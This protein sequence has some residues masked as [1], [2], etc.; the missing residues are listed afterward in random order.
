MNRVDRL[1]GILLMLQRQSKVRAQD[2]A[3]RFEISVRTV[4]RDMTAL[5][6]V[7][8]P[9]Y[10]TP[11]DGYRLSDGYLL[12]PVVFTPEEATALTLG[13]RLLASGS[14]ERLRQNAL[15]ALDKLDAVLPAPTRHRVR[16]RT[17]SVSFFSTRDGLDLDLELVGT[18]QAAIQARRCLRLRYRSE[19]A[20]EALVRRVDPLALSVD[21][22]VW[23]LTG[24]CHLRRDQR[25]FRLNRIEDCT[26]LER[27]FRPR[28]VKPPA[29][30]TLD[31]VVRF[32]QQ[33]L[34]SADE[35]AHYGLV[36]PEG[37]CRR[38]RVND[39]REIRHWVL[40]WGASAEVLEPAPLRSWVRQQA[41]RLTEILT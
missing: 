31:V 40:S 16:Q 37:D 13:A 22:G 10:G 11:N 15:S 26:L 8:V 35:R 1:F 7:G 5:A 38:Y 4:Y 32:D 14:S 33:A 28:T 19:N 24:Y 12:K 25:S 20:R 41:Q 2:V 18:I 29:R 27:R 30:P 6:E 23:Y 34:R 21:R 17:D 9:V 3:E 36:A 39:L